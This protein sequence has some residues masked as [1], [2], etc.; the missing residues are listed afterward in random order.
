MAADSA[1]LEAAFG[2][3]GSSL[4]SP[5]SP[6]AITPQTGFDFEG[7]LDDGNTPQQIVNYL[8][9]TGRGQLAQ[10]YFNLHPP[11]G[12][13]TGKEALNA[14]GSFVTNIAQPE[15]QA[16]GSGFRAVEATP[17]VFA[18]VG[19]K[20]IGNEAGAAS[21]AEQAMAKMKEGDLG[22]NTFAGNTIEQNLGEAGQVVGQIVG[23]T[24]PLG[25]GAEGGMAGGSLGQKVVAGAAEAALP[26][27]IIGAGNASAAVPHASAG[28]V[29][30]GFTE[31]AAGG[32]VVGGA[33]PVL[34]TGAEKAGQAIEDA[35]TPTP[36]AQAASNLTP[37][38]VHQT[39]L[40]AINNPLNTKEQMSALRG[41][42]ATV[43]GMN[44]NIDYTPSPENEKMASVLDPL[45]TQGKILPPTTPENQISNVNNV[46]SAIKEK[47]DALVQGLNEHD[48]NVAQAKATATAAE[49]AKYDAM[50]PD[51]QKSYLATA[52]AEPT[53]QDSGQNSWKSSL[54]DDLNN[55]KIPD[56]VKNEPTLNR[57]ATSLKNATIKLADNV[58]D[59]SAGKL[60][61]RKSFDSYVQQEYGQNFF[62]KGRN[63]SDFSRYVYSLRDTLNNGI[64]DSLPDG[65]LPDGTSFKQS[66]QDQHQ[67]INA[68]D[69]MQ[70]KYVREHPQGSSRTSDFAKNHPLIMRMA[71]SVPI[72]I[73]GGALGLS[74]A[75]LYINHEIKSAVAGK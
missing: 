52:K 74:G 6:A 28:D 19:D 36:K 47:S 20:I 22:T 51:E 8:T 34:A 25:L 5:S 13:N 15:V 14:L 69:E 50:T 41:Q 65:K 21:N 68:S 39:S 2:G 59:T 43:T 33:V 63:A 31:G 35:T 16:V 61:L 30:K 12:G 67:L 49:Q 70:A 45:T 54:K 26:T 42:R 66:L 72:R 71:R 37:E 32:A 46:E 40:D 48:A 58:E 53:A 75:G 9:S 7:A 1:A 44:K 62:D 55:T 57:N 27:G 23:E 3:G 11:D 24:D 29:A 17:K 18:A 38:A 64:A 73:A 10:V 56:P 60:S 4:P